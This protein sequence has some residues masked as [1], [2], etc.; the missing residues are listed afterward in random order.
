MHVSVVVVVVIDPIHGK[1]GGRAEG[2][3]TDHHIKLVLHGNT[4]K[5][6]RCVVNEVVFRCFFELRPECCT[7]LLVDLST[8]TPPFSYRQQ[9]LF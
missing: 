8:E 6:V 3:L 7:E 4:N 5:L 9:L 1:F 2:R